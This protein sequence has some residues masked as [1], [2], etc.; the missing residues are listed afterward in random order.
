MGEIITK[1]KTG[2]FVIMTDG[3]ENSSKMYSHAMIKTLIKAS[4]LEIMYIGA[5]IESSKD[6]GINRSIEYTG[7]KTP[8][9]LRFASQN[10]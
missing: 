9:I 8:D 2:K 6:I 5:D 7:D 4:S 10:I 1:Y 3:F